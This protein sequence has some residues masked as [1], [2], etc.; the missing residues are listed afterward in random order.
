M[1]SVRSRVA[2]LL[3]VSIALACEPSFAEGKKYEFLTGES[4]CVEK[5]RV[6][7][8]KVTAVF[9]GG[10]KLTSLSVR[11]DSTAIEM[12]PDKLL[13]DDYFHDLAAFMEAHPE[14][15][16]S[17]ASGALL[18]VDVLMRPPAE[19]DSMRLLDRLAPGDGSMSLVVSKSLRDLDQVSSLH[20]RLGDIFLATC[21]SDR[22]AAS[23]C[24]RQ[25]PILGFRA[26]YPLPGD[27]DGVIEEDR[28]IRSRLATL[29]KPCD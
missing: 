9:G 3:L 8:Q 22:G 18:K 15:V 11:L 5:D 25:F 12:T 26:V 27:W 20:D 7:D 21:W 29:V 28:E 10:H 16:S 2:V 13:N 19:V 23:R 17:D 4:I 1:L 14:S 6:V 24:Q